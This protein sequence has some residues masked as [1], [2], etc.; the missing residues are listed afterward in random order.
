M[1]SLQLSLPG[2]WAW[3]AA[4]STRTKDLLPAFKAMNRKLHTTYFINFEV[5]DRWSQ[6]LH[7][8]LPRLFLLVLKP[9]YRLA[10]RSKHWQFYVCERFWKRISRKTFLKQWQKFI[11]AARARFAME[12]F[13]VLG[14]HRT[15]FK[16][17]A[18]TKAYIYRCSFCIARV[19]KVMTS[20]LAIL[21]RWPRH[22]ALPWCL[23][24]FFYIN[25]H[26]KI[27]H[28]VDIKERLRLLQAS[29]SLIS[30]FRIFYGQQGPCKFNIDFPGMHCAL[31]SDCLVY[32]CLN[33]V[34]VGFCS[35]YLPKKT[36]CL[37][38]SDF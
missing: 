25:R 27:L 28:F 16:N 8:S 19:L 23:H 4:C 9:F 13:V 34:Q 31:S 37:I 30:L 32:E 36:L 18:C 14:T 10:L 29:R 6:A 21:L 5:K 2:V 20:I 38:S 33:I 26:H 35:T 1:K 17:R 12:A 24:G 22:S 7:L 15:G 3:G 11:E